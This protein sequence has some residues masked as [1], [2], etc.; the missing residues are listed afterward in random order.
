MIFRKKVEAIDVFMHLLFWKEPI[1][2]K[3]VFDD[4]RRDIYV[5]IEAVKR[6]GVILVQ[7]VVSLEAEIAIVLNSVS[8]S[9]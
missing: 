6:N 3:K 1:T 8:K 9:P 4:F 7:I 5:S 2:V